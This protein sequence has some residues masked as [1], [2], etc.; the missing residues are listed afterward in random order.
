M[1]TDERD[2]GSYPRDIPPMWLLLAVLL[3]LT[4]HFLLPLATWLVDPWRQAGWAIV[5]I[6]LLVIIGSA[7]RFQRAGTSVRPF[8]P[9]TAVVATG[10]FRFSRNPMYLGMVVITLGVG[11]TLGTVSP[12]AMPPLLFL[13][14]DRRFVRREEPF[15]RASLGTAYDDY[16]RRVRRWL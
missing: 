7:R 1:T 9:A 8:Q 12:M 3:M 13:V 16:C 11:L 5:A 4:L 14:L 10:A 2:P 6:G 15:L